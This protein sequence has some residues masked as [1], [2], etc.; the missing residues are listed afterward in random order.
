M[1]LIIFIAGASTAEAQQRVAVEIAQQFLALSGKTTEY[2]VS[3]IVN[4]PLLAAAMTE[5]NAPW[6]ELSKKLGQLAARL[7]QGKLNTPVQSQT[8]GPDMKNKKFIHTSVLV[9]ILTGQTKN[10]LNL[11]N[12]PMLAEDIGVDLKDSHMPGDHRAVLVTVGPHQVKG[13]EN[14]IKSII[15]NKENENII[16][17]FIF[18]FLY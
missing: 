10:G 8:V 12:A 2:S 17:L 5:D 6:I 1:T 13:N 7:V 3:G 4:A 16:L 18:T 15:L 9:G 11:I 14:G